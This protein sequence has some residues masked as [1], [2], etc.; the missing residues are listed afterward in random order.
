[1]TGPRFSRFVHRSPNARILI[2]DPRI[3]ESSFMLPRRRGFTLIELLVVIAIIAVLIALLLPAVQSAREA[4]RRAQCVNNL[5]QI[6]LALHNYH[7]SN[8]S[9]PP[10]GSSQITNG[11]V[12][13]CFSMKVRILPFMEQQV[14]FNAVNFSLD[15]EWAQDSGDGTGWASANATAKSI[16]IASYLCPSDYRKGNRNNRE[17][18]VWSGGSINADVSQQSNYA[19]NDGGNR[20]FYG[21]QPN[22]IAYW[23]GSTP[24]QVQIESQTRPTLGFRN[25]SDG[26]SNTAFWAEF[27]KS[28][29]NG[30]GDASDSLGMMYTSSSAINSTTMAVPG[31]I[32]ASELAN[33]TKCLQATNK[34]FSWRGER[35]V[36]QDIGRGGGYSHTQLPNRKSC[37]YNDFQGGSNCYESMAASGSYHPGG[38]NVLFGDGSVRFVK[39]TVGYNIWYALGTRAGGELVSSDSY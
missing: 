19:E 21:G 8:D 7:S 9:L 3:K 39:S 23:I 30:P 17:A 6:G 22:G 27:V 4:A 18:S 35:Y 37:Y 20:M 26:L 14:V 16:R 28:D 29:G 11:N 12:R 13:S 25:V 15:A 33:A 5:K 34:N 10:A 31:N 24:D 2:L 32:L 1:M 36:V 38:V